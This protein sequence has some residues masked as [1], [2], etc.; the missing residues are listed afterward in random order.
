MHVVCKQCSTR[1]AVAGRPAGSTSL[2]NVRVQG[3]VNVGRGGIGFGPGGSISFGPGGSVGLGGP[4]TSKFTCSA[5]GHT[6]DYSP[7]EIKDD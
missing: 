1:I 2:Q 7:D 4:R 6:A 3:P 5:C